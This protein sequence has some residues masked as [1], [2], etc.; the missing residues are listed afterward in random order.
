M[1]SGHTTLRLTMVSLGAIALAS[2]SSSGSSNPS[3]PPPSPP[4]SGHN[5]NPT[6]V[7]QLIAG[8]GTGYAD[9]TAY[10]P[11]MRFPLL[12]AHAY[13]NSQVY[14]PGGSQ[15]PTAGQCNASNYDYPWQD[16]FCETRTTATNIWCPSGKGHQGQ[17]IRGASCKKSSDLDAMG[18]TDTNVVVAA[19]AG[20]VIAKYPHYIKVQSDDETSYINYLHMDQITVS[21]GDRVTRGQRLGRVA[22]IGPSGEAYTTRHLHFELKQVMDLG[23]GPQEVHVNPYASL[24]KAYE[25]LLSVTP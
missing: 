14:R 11:N 4:A 6:P 5:F 22:N 10:R 13:A 7:G 24:I 19:E 2:C 21:L 9:N 15:H 1:T 12:K 3:P 18:D 25:R 8:S 17:D 20:H 16:N 23:G